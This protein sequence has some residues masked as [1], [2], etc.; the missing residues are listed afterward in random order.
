MR[1]LWAGTEFGRA[2]GAS[3]GSESARVDLAYNGAAEIDF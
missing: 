3:K 2:Q 1:D